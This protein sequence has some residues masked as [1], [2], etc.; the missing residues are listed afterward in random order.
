LDQVVAAATL[1]GVVA[2]AAVEFVA[3]AVAFYPL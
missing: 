2:V 1:Y 3:A